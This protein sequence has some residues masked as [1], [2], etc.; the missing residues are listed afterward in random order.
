MERERSRIA[1]DMHDELGSKLTRINFLC[2]RARN[3]LAE[4]SP[5]ANKLDSI[6]STSRDLLHS[7][8]EIV[9]AVDPRNDS[10]EHLVAYLGQY[11]AEYLQNT[12]LPYDLKMPGT[13]PEQ[14]LSA[15]VRHNLFL[16]FEEALGNALKHSND[17]C[18]WLLYNPHLGQRLRIGGSA[19]PG[20][21]SPPPRRRLAAGRN[22]LAGH[23]RPPGNHW[24]AV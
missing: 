4:V 7:L 19:A 2:E 11:T 1:R 22:G 8:D 20:R 9:W 18:R 10:L 6:A 3:A 21:A 12:A 14:A 5:A 16:A 13:V 24:R 17:H 15:E 23:A